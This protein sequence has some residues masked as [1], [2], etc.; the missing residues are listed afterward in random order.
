MLSHSVAS[1][2]L[3][4]T[5]CYL[6]VTCQALLST[7]FSRQAHWSRLPRPTSRDHLNS[8]IELMS[9]GSPALAGGFFPTAP[10]GKP[11]IRAET[12]SKLWNTLNNWEIGLKKTLIYWQN[13]FLQIDH[14]VLFWQHHAVSSW[15]KTGLSGLYRE[16]IRIHWEINVQ[17]AMHIILF[18]TFLPSLPYALSKSP[19]LVSFNISTNLRKEEEREDIFSTSE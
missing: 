4:P 8:G 12:I 6:F 10:P 3:Q 16:D 15:N 14:W 2:S 18:L 7:E 17:T 11:Q 19:E 13:D 9:L 5:D 1:D